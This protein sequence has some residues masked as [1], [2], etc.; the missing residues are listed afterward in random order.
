[1]FELLIIL[2]IVTLVLRI[3]FNWDIHNRIHLKNPVKSIATPVSLFTN[4]VKDVQD[5][6]ASNFLLIYCTFVF[7][8]IKYPKD[9]VG[10]RMA[11]AVWIF[12]LSQIIIIFLLVLLYSQDVNHKNWNHEIRSI[13]NQFNGQGPEKIERILWKNC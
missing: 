12:S 4:T 13:L 8:W 10:K 1:M 3:G 6:D 9:K 11:N 2:F 7:F 5:K